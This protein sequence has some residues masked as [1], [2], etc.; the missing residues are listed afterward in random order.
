MT[1]KIM[2]IVSSARRAAEA[3]RSHGGQLRVISHYDADGIASAAIMV[4]ALTRARKRFHLT[5][6]KQLSEKILGELSLEKPDF[7][8]FLD[9]GSGHLEMIRRHLKGAGVVIIDHHQMEGSLE[10]SGIIQANPVDFGIEDN[11]SGSGVT[12]LVAKAMDVRN[13]DLSSIALVGA[14]GDSQ[15]G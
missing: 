4:K 15:I 1:E 12:Y 10:G 13:K 6:V 7:V 14:I 8:V 3:I 11:I 5:L 9:M 2:E